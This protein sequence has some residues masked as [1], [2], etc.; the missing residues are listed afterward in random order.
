MPETLIPRL[1]VFGWSNLQG[2][3]GAGM[4]S[5]LDHPQLLLTTSGRAALLLAFEALGLGPGDKVLLPTYHCPTMVAPVVALGATPLFYPLDAQGQP[6]LDA[7]EGDALQGVRALLAA[8]YFA[9]PADMARLRR[10]CDAR[11]IA[12]VEDCAHALFGQAGERPIGAWG[13]IAIGSL[14][15]FYPVSEGGCLRLSLRHRVP[16]LRPAGLGSQL[17]AVLDI[18]HAGALFGRLRGLNV[19][20][21]SMFNLRQRLKRGGA[22]RSAAPASTAAEYDGLHIDTNLARRALSA[23]TSLLA[24]RLPRERIVTR[25]RAHYQ[26]YARAFSGMPGLHPLRAELPAQ[27]APYVFPLWVDEPDPSYLTLRQ[28]GVPLSRWNWLWPGMPHDPQ[29]HG[30]RWSHH[31]LQ[32][33]CH[34]DLSNAER[35]QLQACL[36]TS[37]ARTGGACA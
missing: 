13:D 30:I 27:C 23:A 37:Y 4:P 19:A 24:L 26:A 3:R 11:S 5:L 36:L 20:I 6:H 12:L 35:E 16:V 31:V 18:L 33:P 8:H 17:K 14:T 1:P 32:L 15:K 22:A 34:Q 9:L 28:Q 10:W 25:R 29:D 21:C 2:A 7:F